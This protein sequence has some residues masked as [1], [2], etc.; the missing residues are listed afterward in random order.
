MFLANQNYKVANLPLVPEAHI[1]DSYGKVKPKE[2]CWL[3]N[4]R[5]WFTKLQSER[6][7]I[8]WLMD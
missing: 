8:D 6:E 2:N 1:P 7:R 3:T 5:P 4:D